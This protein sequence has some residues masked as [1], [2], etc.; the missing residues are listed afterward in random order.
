MF[1]ISIKLWLDRRI[2]E[3]KELP[4]PSINGENYSFRFWD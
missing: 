1:L 4:L 3:R 2:D